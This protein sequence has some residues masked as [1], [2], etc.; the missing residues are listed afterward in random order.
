MS[1]INMELQRALSMA[2]QAICNRKRRVQGQVPGHGERLFTGC[3]EQ[4]TKWL[5]K[6]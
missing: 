1:T 5:W 4:S 6:K 2:A 3:K